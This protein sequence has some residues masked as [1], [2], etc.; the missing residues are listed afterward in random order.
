MS[1]W[2][3]NFN[4]Y[5]FE[6]YQENVS[7]IINTLESLRSE[8]ALQPLVLNLYLIMWKLEPRV[9]PYLHKILLIESLEDAS[10][11]HN[12]DIVRAHTIKEICFERYSLLHAIS[13]FHFLV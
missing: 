13:L 5:C 10:L 8:A 12:W 9:F 6:P 3:F 7:L 2:I 11:Q 1:Q 4:F